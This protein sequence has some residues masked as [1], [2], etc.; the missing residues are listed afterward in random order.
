MAPVRIPPAP[1]LH[2]NPATAVVRKQI[3]ARRRALFLRCRRRGASPVL[4]KLSDRAAAIPRRG[5]PVPSDILRRAITQV[6]PRI[7]NRRQSANRNI[8]AFPRPRIVKLGRRQSPANFR[9]GGD[10]SSALEGFSGGAG[11]FRRPDGV[12]GRRN[13]SVFIVRVAVV[14]KTQSRA[15]R[16]KSRRRKII[17]GRPENRRTLR[18]IRTGQMASVGNSAARKPQRNSATAVVRGKNPA[19]ILARLQPERRGRRPGCVNRYLTQYPVYFT[20]GLDL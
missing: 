7:P 11:A 8:N 18:R 5:R 13:Q 14:Y 16:R 17:H 20:G 1:K 12:D 4:K 3:P 10:A 6:R 9:A 2:Q 19:R 15:V